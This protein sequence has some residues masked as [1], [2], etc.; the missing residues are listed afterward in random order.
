[1]GRVDPGKTTDQDSKEEAEEIV[2]VVPR[3]P[4]FP[5]ENVIKYFDNVTFIL[6]IMVSLGMCIF[7]WVTVFD[8]KAEFKSKVGEQ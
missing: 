4:K 1:M 7:C 2:K 5:I 8:N 3:K 6:N